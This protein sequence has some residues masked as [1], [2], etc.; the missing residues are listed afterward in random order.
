MGDGEAAPSCRPG[1]HDLRFQEGDFAYLDSYF[2]G[3][4]FLGQEVVYHQDVP[5]WAM[6]Y[7]GRIL[8]PERIT[9]TEAGQIIKES[10]SLLY[11]EGRFLGGFQHRTRESTYSDTNQGEVTCFTG[12]EWITRNGVRVYELHYHGGL[13]KP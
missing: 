11:R 12:E 6:N 2:G 3:S 1:S 8:E 5:V 9:A 13:I 7:Y 10:L 4:D